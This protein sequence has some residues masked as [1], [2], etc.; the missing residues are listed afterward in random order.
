MTHTFIGGATKQVRPLSRA[1][2]SASEADANAPIV[3]LTYAHAGAELLTQLLSASPPVACTSATGLLP[4]CHEAISAWRQAQGRTGPPSALAIKSVRAL[5]TAMITII[6]ARDG[7]SRW[8]EIAYS[9]PDVAQTFLQIF[10]A[11][12]FICLYRSMSE[13]LSEAVRTYLWGL[14]GT[15]MWAY[16]TGHPG[17]NAATIAAYWTARTQALLEFESA[18]PDCSLR[19]RYEDLAADPVRHAADIFATLGLDDSQLTVLPEPSAVEPSAVHEA[20]AGAGE[21]TVP[22]DLIPPALMARAGELHARLGFEF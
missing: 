8:C 15:P 22:T 1:A 18:H 4:V 19:V 9:T 12:Q 5:A 11:T 14:G 20:A 2:A 10:P 6:Q 21:P 3:V 16:A 17:N 13:V 7:A